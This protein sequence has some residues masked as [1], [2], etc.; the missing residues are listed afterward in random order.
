MNKWFF[1]ILLFALCHC[2]MGQQW[3]VRLDEE[4]EGWLFDLI[5]V[6]EGEQALGIGFHTNRSSNCKDGVIYK[7]DKEGNILSRVVHLPSKTL[8]YFS[9][10]QLP[11]WCL[12]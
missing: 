10:V 12:R 3:S 6:D 8:E 11:I 7:A 5:H 1:T 2:L 4:S 9:A